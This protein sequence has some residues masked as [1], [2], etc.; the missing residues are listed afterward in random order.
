[1]NDPVIMA[2]IALLVGVVIGVVLH[3]SKV[4][5]NAKEAGSLIE[6]ARKESQAVLREARLQ[7]HDEMYKVREL[8]DKETRERR[9]EFADAE[10][11]LLQRE[12]NLDR[13]G[14]SLDRKNDQ[15]SQ[16]ERTLAQREAELFKLQDEL[17]VMKKGLQVE[18]QRISGLT[19]E[20]ARQRLLA[21]VEDDVRKDAASLTRNILEEAKH[22]AEEEAKRIITISIERLAS[23]HVQSVTSCLL[24][25][26]SEEMKGRIIGREGR[27]IRAFEA[28]TGVN[29]LIDDTPQ[30]VVL[31]AFDPVR[32]EVARQTME[33]LVADGRINPARIEEEAAK[34]GEEVQ[35]SIRK[36]GEDA[37]FTLGLARVAPEVSVVLG[38]LKF[39]HSFAQNVLDHSIEVAHIMTAMAGELGLNMEIAKRVGLFHDIGK[40]LD[41]DVEGAHAL[42]GA[43]LLRKHGEAE[44]VYQGVASHHHEVEPVTV[45]GVLAGAADAISASRP[46]ARSESTELYISRLE[47][48]EA[49][50]NSFA[51][52]EKSYA[53]QAGREVRIIVEP[54]QVSDAEATVLAREIRKKVEQELQYPG[55]I[56]VTVVRET[57]VVEYAK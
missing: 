30:T 32:R 51:G 38:R 37:V 42:I 44:A 4:R 29:V 39:R 57:R 1:M 34:A 35:Q 6:A 3:W 41:H 54:Q 2:V 15:Q 48:L 53:L 27:N 18:L 20:E 45:Y 21:Q 47:Q 22:G 14:E 40:A 26:P 50:A 19:V 28:A 16:Q 31:S 11:R 5:A 7:S 24:T 13:K 55:Q 23:S 33:R 10:K 9:Q 46:G 12:T 36:A 8:F 52:V 25:L 43:Q 17:D 56:K 49:I